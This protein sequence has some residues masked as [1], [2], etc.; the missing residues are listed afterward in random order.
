ML[1][2]CLL[3]CVVALIYRGAANADQKE[4]STRTLYIL[5]KAG[6]P[7]ITLQGDDGGLI[8]IQ[9]AGEPGQVTIGYTPGGGF[10]SITG[11]GA[12]YRV[13]IAGDENGGRLRIHDKDGKV[14]F[15]K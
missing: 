15:E 7:A 4:I 3:V 1:A 8:G 2:V 12:D 10:L 13:H 14:V 6:N 11:K 9:K 5:D